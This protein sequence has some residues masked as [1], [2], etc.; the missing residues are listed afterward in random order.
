[1]VSGVSGYIGARTL[2]DNLPD[3]DRLHGDR[4][5]DR[6]PKAFLSAI[7]LAATVIYRL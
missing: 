2:C 4:G 7:A 3:V 1:M 6:C 5:Y